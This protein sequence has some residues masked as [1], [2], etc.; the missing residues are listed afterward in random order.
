MIID[1][2]SYE[3]IVLIGLQLNIT[4]EK[5]N[6]PTIFRRS[7]YHSTFYRL[8]V[9]IDYYSA[10]TAKLKSFFEGFS[11]FISFD[12]FLTTNYFVVLSANRQLFNFQTIF[13]PILPDIEALNIWVA[14]LLF[15]SDVALLALTTIFNRIRL[16]N[17]HFPFVIERKVSHHVFINLPEL[18]AEAE[19]ALHFW[20]QADSLHFVADNRLLRGRREHV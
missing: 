18:I 19:T 15:Y 4:P 14:D 10:F 16:I 5:I 13:I 20:F 11:G 2:K 3:H 6:L 7:V 1:E 8:F 9:W 17:K 12:Q